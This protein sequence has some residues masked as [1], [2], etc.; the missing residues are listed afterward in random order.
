MTAEEL[1]ERIRMIRDDLEAG[2]RLDMSRDY[3]ATCSLDQ[4]N[5]LLST[6][7]DPS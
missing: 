2:F 3:I 1:I 6:V 5:A 7:G 4:L